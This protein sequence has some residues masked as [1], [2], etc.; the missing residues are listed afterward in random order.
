MARVDGH[1]SFAKPACGS[2][3]PFVSACMQICRAMLQLVC[4][5]GPSEPV[6]KYGITRGKWK[7]EGFTLKVMI[8]FSMLLQHG[9]EPSFTTII[10]LLV[11]CH[12]Q[13]L[14]HESPCKTFAGVSLWI[15]VVAQ[16]DG[17]AI[18]CRPAVALPPGSF[19]LDFLFCF[20]IEAG[21][22]HNESSHSKQRQTIPGST[23]FF[24]T[25]LTVLSSAFRRDSIP[26]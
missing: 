15:S 18:W 1:A 21:S 23:F 10:V 24:H 16:C 25:P 17:D 22:C 13:A 9:K 19:G 14:T 11:L 7:Y 12:P 4:T 26:P 5:E 20:L 3:S 8:D 2:Q 6:S